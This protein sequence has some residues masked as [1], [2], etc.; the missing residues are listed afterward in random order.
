[1][2]KYIC[3]KKIIFL[4]EGGFLMRINIRTK[5]SVKMSDNVKEHITKQVMELDKLFN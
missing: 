3:K 5:G 4:T 2:I 1:M